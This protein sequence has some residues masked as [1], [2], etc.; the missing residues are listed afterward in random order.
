MAS[1]PPRVDFY[2]LQ[3][4]GSS[5]DRLACRL[6]GKGFE[7]GMRIFIRTGS[8]EHARALDEMLWTFEQLS[9]LPHGL[10]GEADADTPIQIGTDEPATMALLI[11]LADTSP[12]PIVGHQRIAEIVG[13]DPAAKH[14]GRL[15]YKH[16]QRLGVTPTT[17][18]LDRL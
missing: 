18:K 13:P 17:H 11:N 10:S 7:K 12:D 2:V 16:Y 5:P 3:R 8:P 15:R 6:T 4:A 9:F 1:H 14:S